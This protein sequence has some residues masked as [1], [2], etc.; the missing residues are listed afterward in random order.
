MDKAKHSE[1]EENSWMAIQTHILNQAMEHHK[2]GYGT[3][4][5]ELLKLQE[6]RQY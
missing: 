3:I 6:L 1:S 2:I 5:Y 4:S